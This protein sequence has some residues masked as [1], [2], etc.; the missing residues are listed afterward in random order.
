MIGSP[1]QWQVEGL[2]VKSVRSILSRF[3]TP[4]RLTAALMA[5]PSNTQFLSQWKSF[6]SGS[7]STRSEQRRIGDKNRQ[8]IP[9]TEEVSVH[10]TSVCVATLDLF[11]SLF[12]CGWNG[13]DCMYV[14]IE[15]AARAV[16]PIVN[17]CAYYRDAKGERKVKISGIK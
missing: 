2:G 14:E 13:Y 9:I 16:R 12:V 8:R 3:Q 6:S 17:C 7:N 4:A 5:C 15:F 10:L 1:I 11:V